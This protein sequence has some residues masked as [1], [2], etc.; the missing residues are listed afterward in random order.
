MD[1][2]DHE[3]SLPTIK[4]KQYTSKQ[5]HQSKGF[6]L[7]KKGSSYLPCHSTVDN[8]S[9]NKYTPKIKLIEQPKQEYGNDEIRDYI[10]R[11]KRKQ[12]DQSRRYKLININRS[13]PSTKQVT[14]EATIFNSQQNGNVK[15]SEAIASR[16]RL[17][18]I[19]TQYEK[20]RR[21]FYQIYFSFRQQSASK[22]R[23]SKKMPKLP[24]KDQL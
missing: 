24:R 21:T 20:E 11:L 14:K 12:L 18:G 2:G 10:R 22:D 17:Y 3:D 15:S 6:V 19:K 13:V 16:A 5:Y 4:K 9:D 7:K 23:F 8:C 1:S